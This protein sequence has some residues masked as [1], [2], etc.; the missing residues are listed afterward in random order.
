MVA[1][2]AAASE[3]K[4]KLEDAGLKY[5]SHPYNNPL[6]TMR[7]GWDFFVEGHVGHYDDDTAGFDRDGEFR[8]LYVGVDYSLT[9]DVLIGALGQ[10]DDTEEDVSN[11]DLGNLKGEV[12]GTGW[13]FGPFVGI[14]LTENLYFDARAAYGKSDN[15]IWLNDTSAGKRTGDFDTDRWLATATL[16][17]AQ[18][19]GDWRLSPQIGLAYGKEWYDDFRN[20]LGQLVE[21]HDIAIGRL[22]GAI[23]VGYKWETSDGTRVEPHMSITGIWNFATD[24]LEIDGASLDRDESRAKLEGGV[25][26]TT[27]QGWGLRAAGA[28]D[29]IG[30]DDLEAYSGSVWVNIPLN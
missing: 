7:Q 18:Y 27:P 23:E 12:E 19:F 21:G 22:T 13:M 28:Y 2:Q 11:R 3:E 1:A 30:S 14:R 4:K 5:E 6:A 24:D 25:L 9:P 20:S 8:I 15:D 29:G 10:I 16:T 26:V 17:G